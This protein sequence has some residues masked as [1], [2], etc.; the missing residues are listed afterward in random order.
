MPIYRE[1]PA[2]PGRQGK[3]L[4]SVGMERMRRLGILFALDMLLNDLVRMMCRFLK[5]LI[6][7][8]QHT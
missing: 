2:T 6:L 3:V 1:R 8:C 7:I 4:C 5:P